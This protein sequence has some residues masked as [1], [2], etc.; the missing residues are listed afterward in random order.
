M[1]WKL[2]SC[3]TRATLSVV[4][5]GLLAS[6]ACA[7]GPPAPASE[8]KQNANGSSD[9]TLK[10]DNLTF[11]DRVSWRSRLNWPQDCESTF[12]YPD[13]SFAGLT[14]YELSSEQNLVQVTCTLG[15]Y[16]GA[17]VFMLLDESVS[18]RKATLLHFV[19]YEDSGEQ[20]AGRL[21]KTEATSLTGT[22]EFDS[23]TK[24]LRVLNKFRGLGDC[25]FQ[26]TYSFSKGQPQLILLQG[27]LNCDGKG[28]S[29]TRDWKKLPLS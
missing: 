9:T 26:T 28:A 24:Q 10:R 7:A 16:Q 15:A 19:T 17:Y 27:K 22:P 29:N 12:D 2:D 11:A 3:S 21:Q 18:P 4:L 5:L 20:G 14:F 23:A 6:L 1:N 13:K 8:T 25:G